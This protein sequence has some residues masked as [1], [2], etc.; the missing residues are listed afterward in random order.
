M[1]RIA[2]ALGA[3][4]EG[5]GSPLDAVAEYV[6]DAPTL[7]VL[8]ELEHI[9]GIAPELDELLA[10]CPG[11]RILATSRTM[12]RIRAEREY[13]VGP[14]SVP[15]FVDRPK[16]KDVA[17]LPAVRLFVDRAQAARYGFALTDENAP[18]VVE[19]C[20]R[21]DGLPLAIELAAARTRLLDPTALL[22]RL[23][24]SLDAL[25][26]GPADL[27]E[28]QRTLRATVEWSF[29]LL[30][31]DE[32][33]M[34]AT[35][36]IFVDG[37]TLDAAVH[38]SGLTEDRTLDLIDALAGH[39]L[40]TVDPTGSEP[41][42]RMV[43]SV[44]ELAAERLADREDHADIE[45]R[46]AMFFRKL[47]EESAWPTEHQA[48]W[49]DRLGREE[50]NIAAAIRWS[51]DHDIAPLPYLFRILWLFWQARDRMPEGRGWIEE[52][53]ARADEL[54]ARGQAEL[55]L[56]SAITAVEVGDDDAALVAAEAIERLEPRIDDPSIESAAHLADLVGAADPR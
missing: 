24:T 39:S 48:A 47:V 14:L 45:R 44:R 54:D 56:I 8:D 18:A 33:G 38:V 35:L 12:L 51:L 15:T 52:L 43:T 49:T 22:D 36:S 37:W 5:A 16:V 31:I 2:S 28:R 41:R 46:H 3:S 55:M 27:P 29:G 19:I 1:P 17:S 25:G 40:V 10:R 26:V 50:G 9:V 23:R 6:A 20:R 42:F 30:E 11:L 53:M 34:I 4:I 7:L 13:P 32:L 21:L